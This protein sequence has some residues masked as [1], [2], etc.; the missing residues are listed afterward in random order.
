[1]EEE[2]KSISMETVN[3]N[4]YRLFLELVQIALGKRAMLS[5]TPTGKEWKELFV[6]A[7][8]QSVAGMLF[9]ALDS[10]S[11]NGQKPPQ[12]ILFKWIGLYE[13]IKAS[14]RLLNQRCVDITAHFCKEGYRSCI[15][16][17][18]GNALSYPDPLSRNSGDIDIWIESS[19]ENIRDKVRKRFPEAEECAWH[20]DYPI[21]DDVTI[22]VHFIPSY[23]RNPKY[24]RR[25]QEYFISHEHEQFSHEAQLPEG[26]GKI[27]IPTFEFNVFQQLSHIMRHF[28]IEGIG[29]RQI[30]DFYYLLASDREPAMMD[31]SEQLKQFGM[32]S[33]TKAVMWIMVSV[34]CLDEK[35]LIAPMDEKHGRLLLKEILYGGNWGRYDNRTL[36]RAKTKRGNLS[37]LA[38]SMRL[39]WT[40]PKE[41]ILTP[42]IK[43]IVK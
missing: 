40:F 34:C 4:V 9:Q 14:N 1:M 22:E 3:G 6:I 28:F 7:Q 20:I 36:G 38:H 35:L 11:K 24:N 21:F 23:L 26:V 5:D 15:L 10:L 43:R 30:M 17:G 8:Q 42:I 16:K 13:Q 31:Y 37:Y 39:A 33:F 18:Q 29:L 32:Y 2:S 41:V 27:C 19:R 25:L 12:D